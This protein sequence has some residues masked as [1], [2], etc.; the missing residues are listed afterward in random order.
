VFR[1]LD[2]PHHQRQLRRTVKVY[3]VGCRARTSGVRKRP[4]ETSIPMKQRRRAGGEERWQCANCP[5]KSASANVVGGVR[6]Q[7]LFVVFL[8]GFHGYEAFREIETAKLR[9]SSDHL[10]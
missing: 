6:G 4:V 8:R 7:N 5:E 10:A 9:F 1:V 3:G 2:E